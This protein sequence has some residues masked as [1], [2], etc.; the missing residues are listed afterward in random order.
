MQVRGFKISNLIVR[1]ENPEVSILD[2]L[3]SADD[4]AE[5]IVDLKVLADGLE[6]GQYLAC[7][8]LQVRQVNH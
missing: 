3:K 8:G 2:S 5:K 1:S 4:L 6:I 7:L